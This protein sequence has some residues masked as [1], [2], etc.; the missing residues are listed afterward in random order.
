MGLQVGCMR[1][2]AGARGDAV[3]MQWGCRR[4]GYGRLRQVTAGYGRLRRVTAG[5]DLDEDAHLAT[6]EVDGQV[7]V[8]AHLGTVHAL[9]MV[10]LPSVLPY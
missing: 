8:G 7:L 3:G 10:S 9:H 4:A 2:Q 6:E 5:V 1:L